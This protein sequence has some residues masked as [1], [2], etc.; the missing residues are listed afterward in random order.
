MMIL[1]TKS[2]TPIIGQVASV[3][4]WIM[5]GIYKMLDG[6]FGVQNLG[7]C[8][9][10]FSII[11]YALMTPLQIKQQKFSKLSAFMQPELQKVQK[12]YQGKRDQVSM[13][14]VNEE[15]QAIYQKYGV[16]PTGSC[17]QLAIQ[18]PILMALWQVI[19]KIPA[20]VG[21]VKDI[22]TEA[23]SHITAVDGYTQLVQNF[24]TD[25]KITRVQLIMDGSQATSNSIID[26]LYALSPSQWEKLATVDQFSGFSGIIDTTAHEISKMQ[27][28]FGLNIADQPMTY[29]KA[30]F[31]GGAIILA[32]AALMIPI[33]SWVTQML[34]IK[35]MPQAA[36]QDGEQNA[37]M[38]SMKMMNTIMPLMSAIFCFTFPVGLGIYWI[39]SA[40]VRSIQQLLIN[41]HMDRMN[42]DDLINENMKKMEKKR[43][44]AGL[45]PQK[46]TNQAH[47]N[48]KNINN[49]KA[50][51]G[52]EVNN[53]AERARKVEQSYQNAAKAKPGSITAKANMVRDFDERNR[54]K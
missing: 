48:V 32:I 23:V 45:P 52:A 16:S 13:Q 14:K 51:K 2:G 15:T 25:N 22:F 44:K 8:I 31:T 26:F 28:F 7:I 5:D 17:V 21:S 41:R 24:I 10:I 9:I 35:L 30:A 36:Q 29:I 4:G 27:N 39:S 40:V 18:F 34:N 49:A 43:E 12:K 20:Y 47:Q 42:I 38:N 6:L 1:A 11:I 50:Q 19:Y 33:L 46:I 37:M 54:K 3:M 53:A